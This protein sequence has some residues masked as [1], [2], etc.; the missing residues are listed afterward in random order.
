VSPPRSP[1]AH[2]ATAS[3]VTSWTRTARNAAASR[4]LAASLVKFGLVFAL[5]AAPWPGLGHAFTGAVGSIATAIADPLSAS[6]NVTVVVRSPNQDEAQPDWRGVIAVREDLPSG[7]LDRAGAID[8]RRAG[9]L[10]L[11]TFAALAVAW[12]PSGRR[13][14]LLAASVALAIVA[15]CTAV[16]ILA[17]L[18]SVGAVDPGTALGALLSLASRALVAAPGMAFAVPGLSWLALSPALREA[19]VKAA[20]LGTASSPA[21]SPDGDS[22]PAAARTVS[23]GRSG[24]RSE[25]SRSSASARTSRRRPAARGARPRE[26]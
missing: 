1:P 7:P 3:V 22:P 23:P 4:K 16:P 14:A 12:P 21:A 26:A 9:Y 24:R 15:M 10:Q 11:A 18:S 5:L 17:F 2:S 19:A 13:R 25:R 6:S 20:A 8:L